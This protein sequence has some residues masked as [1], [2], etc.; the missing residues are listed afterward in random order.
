MMQVIAEDNGNQSENDKV[1]TD[2]NVTITRLGDSSGKH[3]Q[4]KGKSSNV[5]HL[6]IVNSR[7]ESQVS[8][9]RSTI[10]SL[11]LPASSGT[12]S[13]P[14][15][16]GSSSVPSIR[17]RPVT[18]ASL[19]RP[20]RND[21]S[22]RRPSTEPSPRNTN[23]RR[24]SVNNKTNPNKQ[25]FTRLD[26]RFFRSRQRESA[27]NKN[28]PEVP[29]EPELKPGE[30]H[31][32]FHSRSKS[33]YGR[34]NSNFV[35]ID[36]G[37]VPQAFKGDTSENMSRL[38]LDSK[39]GSFKPTEHG[40]DMTKHTGAFVYPEQNIM[41]YIHYKG[42]KFKTFYFNPTP[43]CDLESD[44]EVEDVDDVVNLLHANLDMDLTNME[45]NNLPDINQASGKPGE[46]LGVPSGMP[47][48][49]T[50][51]SYKSFSNKFAPPPA[52]LVKRR[53]EQKAK[54]EEENARKFLRT[55]ELDR[56]GSVSD[57]NFHS[58]TFREEDG[59]YN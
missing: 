20:I 33:K 42:R 25:K 3:F 45:M 11:M 22:P 21:S 51:P 57:W 36:T 1:G 37:S 47:Q 56:R 24:T 9:A 54:E 18:G 23:K 40:I 30:L 14:T 5:D 28:E 50:T 39:G 43:R 19:I 46:G 41:Q 44:E 52:S 26:G 49:S 48:R 29:A 10:S 31:R 35:M 4:E 32:V 12:G 2:E 38:S 17:Q 53:K 59:I 16:R 8:S 55:P 13:R 7:Q 58:M 27:E 6:P 34:R 15:T